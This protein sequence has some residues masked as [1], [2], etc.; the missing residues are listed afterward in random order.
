MIG[1][2]KNLPVSTFPVCVE[3]DKEEWKLHEKLARAKRL[4]PGWFSFHH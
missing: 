1:E 2:K 3:G 4:E